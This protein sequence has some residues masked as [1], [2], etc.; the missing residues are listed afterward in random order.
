MDARLKHKDT[1]LGQLLERHGFPE[2]ACHSS[3]GK[4]W[5]D[6]VEKALVLARFI[7]GPSGLVIVIDQIKEKFGGLRFYWSNGPNTSKFDNDDEEGH[8]VSLMDAVASRAERNC[9]YICE[10]CGA[11][12][13][14]RKAGGY[15]TLCDKCEIARAASTLSWDVPD[16]D[17]IGQDQAETSPIEE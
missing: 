2:P 15:K 7:Q 9:A 17:G 1:T 3:I 5:F 11:R 10:C 8:W 4:G 6:E 12:G 13:E 16:E 14:L